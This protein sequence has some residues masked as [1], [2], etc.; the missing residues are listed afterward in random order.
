MSSAFSLRALITGSTNRTV[1]VSPDRSHTAVFEE[2]KFVS[3]RVA[4]R[5]KVGLADC[6]IDS[7]IPAP[8]SRRRPLLLQVTTLS[9]GESMVTR[10]YEHFEAVW[11]V[12][13]SPAA[14]QLFVFAALCD[15]RVALHAF[16]I[17]RRI[18]REYVDVALNA[19]CVAAGLPLA[20]FA[21]HAPVVM[22]R[23]RPKSTPAPS[24]NPPMDSKPTVLCSS[25]PDLVWP[26]SILSHYSLKE[27]RRLFSAELWLVNLLTGAARL[28]GAPGAYGNLS[29]S[30][31]G[32]FALCDVIDLRCRTSDRLSAS[33]R[34]TRL[35]DCER[36]TVID[37]R[38]LDTQ[39]VYDGPNAISWHPQSASTVVW[40]EADSASGEGGQRQPLLNAWDVKTG[41]LNG[42]AVL[43]PG[44]AIAGWS[45][46]G[47]LVTYRVTGEEQ[48]YSCLP[49]PGANP[50]QR[51]WRIVYPPRWRIRP[52]RVPNALWSAAPICQV[53]EDIFFSTEDDIG[54]VTSLC[55]LNTESRELAIS[56]VGRPGF[57]ERV[58]AVTDAREGLW[59][60]EGP[61]E[62]DHL[63]LRSTTNKCERPVPPLVSDTRG[64]AAQ[65]S[66]LDFADHLGRLSS[67]AV[68]VGQNSSKHR[69]QP[70]LVWIYPV[71]GELGS[72][73]RS[74]FDRSRRYLGAQ[75]LP[76]PAV[77]TAGINVVYE[78][79]IEVA[80][81]GA[82]G[83]DQYLP[84]LIGSVSS[85]VEQLL[86]NKL[87]APGRLIVGGHSYGANAALNVLAN[88]DLFQAGIGCSGIYNRTLTPLGFQNEQ[89][90]V[91]KARDAY[92]RQS[93]L[94]NVQHITAPVLLIYGEQDSEPG[95]FPLQSR[96]MFMA[97]TAAGATARCVALPW[98]GHR[99]TSRVAVHRVLWEVIRWC[100]QWAGGASSG[101]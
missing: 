18:L 29:L 97:L 72:A 7:T 76:I 33:N 51:T 40:I 23:V 85:L 43:T 28:A 84:A 48:Y 4:L 78:P 73:A 42:L 27:F 79:L 14:P 87:A 100:R 74:L 75:E 89:R 35:L 55:A 30:P 65:R 59:R 88:S 22:V 2:E 21:R 34:K 32:L 12:G 70:C 95:N 17:A 25:N 60:V 86:A 20:V 81:P 94:L 98:E 56:A 77:S 92:L 26:L 11:P 63:L 8:V 38:P 53:G 62:P 13:F 93:P 58:I 101:S 31:D 44:E 45:T 54:G 91:W 10:L 52:I 5:R 46:S 24:L 50:E 68:F 96:E 64:V 80:A 41:L 6:E 37:C 82:D 57:T 47:S 66:T 69:K 1:F 19:T 90:R 15:G 99:F 49:G 36:G 71:S 61:N 83:N 3:S 67:A 39:R 16:D 9:T